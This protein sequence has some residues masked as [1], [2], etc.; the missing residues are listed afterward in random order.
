[1]E[2]IEQ[3]VTTQFKL[4]ISSIKG[5]TICCPNKFIVTNVKGKLE[6]ETI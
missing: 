1:M 5:E 4:L 3:I 2:Q 6:L